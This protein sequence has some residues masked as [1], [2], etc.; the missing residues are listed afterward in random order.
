MA[1]DWVGRK[2]STASIVT[3]RDGH[4]RNRVAILICQ[5][6]Y[7]RLRKLSPCLAGLVI[8]S[9]QRDRGNRA[10]RD[11]L[12]KRYGYQSSGRRCKQHCSGCGRSGIGR[13]GFARGVGNHRR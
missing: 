10:G 4:T 6:D 7:Q 2:A 13:L 3:K 5:C 8:A 9:T 11:G 12:G 1:A